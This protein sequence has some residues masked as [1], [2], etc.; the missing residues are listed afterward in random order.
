VGCLLARREALAKLQ[1]P[2][3]SG[4]T[5]VAA[6]VQRQYHQSAAGAAHF[7]DGTLNYLSVPAVE[8]GLQFLNRIGMDTIHARVGALGAGLLDTLTSL[9]HTNG[10]PAV[11][12]YGP[13]SWRG[14]GATLAFNFLHPRRASRR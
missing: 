4:G 8:I 1:R 9:R 10:A 3:F 13:R 2:W 7:E 11:T 14:R 6:L 12:I 5:I